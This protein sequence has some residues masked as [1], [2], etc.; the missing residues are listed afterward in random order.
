MQHFICTSFR[1]S[2][3]S[4]GRNNKIQAGIGQGNVVL[5]NICQ[6]SSYLIIKDIEK[7]KKGVMIRTPIT[8]Q[9]EQ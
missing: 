4:Y 5:V 3:E 7:E 9:E 6:D 8:R 2:S 1:I